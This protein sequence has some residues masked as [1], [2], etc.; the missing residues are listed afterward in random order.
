MQV[1]KESKTSVA[2]FA[3]AWTFEYFGGND[4]FDERE[5]RFWIGNKEKSN[6]RGIYLLYRE[7]GCISHQLEEKSYF[8]TNW[9]YTNFDQGFG[10]D[11]YI[12][13]KVYIF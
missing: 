4:G 10:Q 5:Y 2:L 7:N 3:P 13:G 9:F 1:I 11:L 8:E 12:N 6:I